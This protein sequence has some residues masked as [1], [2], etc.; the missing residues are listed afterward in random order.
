MNSSDKM[1]AII[2]IRSAVGRQAKASI[3]AQ[4]PELKNVLRLTYNPF[5]HYNIKPTVEWL[6]NCGLEMLDEKTSQL[7]RGLAHGRLTGSAAKRAVLLEFGRLEPFSQQLLFHIL[8]KDMR[9]GMQAKSI[10][11]V[12]PGLI[13]EFP[14]QLAH[15]FEE[16]RL[17]FPIIGTY[18]V[19]GLRCLYENGRLYSRYGRRFVGL[20]K[21]EKFL[22]DNNA[23]KLDGELTVPGKAFDDLSGNIRSFK[24]SDDVTYNIF[25]VGLNVPQHTRCAN[26]QLLALHL[27]SPMVKA[28]PSRTLTT[29]AEIDDMFNEARDEGYEGLVLKDENALPCNGRTYAWMKV[30]AKDTVDVQVTGI[31]EGKGKYEG[32]VGALVCDFNGVDIQVGGGLTDS[33]REVWFENPNL[34]MGKTVEVEYMEISKYGALR[35]PRFKLVRGDK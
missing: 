32:H 31:K 14:V 12:W 7:L 17:T 20:E 1:L 25:D 18:K 6:G 33:Q 9:M 27:N 5:I 8:I 26:V 23:P 35:H 10:N 30:K 34:I 29:M 21:L 24:Q 28:V 3:L 2:Q 16:K 15:V 4:Y 11:K 13:P 19:D 22:Q